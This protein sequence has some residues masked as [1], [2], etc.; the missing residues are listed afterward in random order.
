MKKLA[1]LIF[2]FVSFSTYA[3]NFTFRFFEDSLNEFTPHT[4]TIEM[5]GAWKRGSKVK[6]VVIR[7]VLRTRTTDLF[8]L[9]GRSLSQNL[10]F[11]WDGNTLVLKHANGVLRSV[12]TA[13]VSNGWGDTD[14]NPTDE[15]SIWIDGELRLNQSGTEGETRFEIA[16]QTAEESCMWGILKK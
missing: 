1:L 9:S 2:A 5:D 10:K 7:E 12:V 13:P 4:L 8:V 15:Y 6:R 16:N 11:R 14:I 3:A